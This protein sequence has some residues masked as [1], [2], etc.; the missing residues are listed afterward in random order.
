MCCD[1]RWIPSS[2]FSRRTLENP[3]MF[4]AGAA[5]IVLLVGIVEMDALHGFFTTTNLTS[6]QWLVC[7]AVGS[8]IL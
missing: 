5:V 7:A 8:T 3:S 1:N 2:V 4:V 6:S